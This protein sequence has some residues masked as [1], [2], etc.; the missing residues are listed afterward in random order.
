MFFEEGNLYHIF[1]Q[2]NNREKIF[3]SRDNYIFFLEKIKKYIIPHADIIAWCLMP[4]HFHLM[5]YVLGEENSTHTMTSSHRMS[6]NH[7]KMNKLSESLAIMLRSYTRAINV[8]E[9]RSGSLFKAHTKSEC[10]TQLQ[11]TSPST[12][13]TQI[14]IYLPEKEYP[15][16]C[17]NYIHDNPV[18]AR[19]VKQSEDWEFSS[20]R[21][22][23]GLRNGKLVS[24]ERMKEFAITL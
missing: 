6:N 14:P 9:N 22:Y 16:I 2:G 24:K 8:Q 13:E 4:N 7:I 12:Y 5:V 15:Q 20:Y 1:N 19:L 11:G 21:D 17:F 23:Y 18:A 3:F 10:L